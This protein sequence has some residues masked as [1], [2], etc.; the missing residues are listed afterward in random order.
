MVGDLLLLSHALFLAGLFAFLGGHL[1]YVAAFALRGLDL[2]GALLAAPLLIAALFVVARWLLPHV[3]GA[4]RGPVLVYMAVITVMVIAAASTVQHRPA[5]TLAIGATAFYLSDLAV[6]RERFV[7]PGF[8]NRA[9][10][11]P[12]Y[13]A[14]QFLLAWSI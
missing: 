7:E 5:W 1:A 2:T 13:Y 9:W 6:A 14:A 11:L 4:M 10:G 8:V 3:K 12:V